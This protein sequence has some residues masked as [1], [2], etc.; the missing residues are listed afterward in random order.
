VLERAHALKE[1]HAQHAPELQVKI[2]FARTAG[3]AILVPTL[4]RRL[5]V[6]EA[7]KLL[8]TLL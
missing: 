4:P 2:A 6:V 5:A 7:R 1:A 8:Q 3:A